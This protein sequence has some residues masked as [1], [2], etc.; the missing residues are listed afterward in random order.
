M[1]NLCDNIYELLKIKDNNVIVK[2]ISQFLAYH[3]HKIDKKSSFNKNKIKK[4][5]HLGKNLKKLHP[6][7]SIWMLNP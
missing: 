6:F 7:S 5:R 2:R 3:M 4:F 1:P